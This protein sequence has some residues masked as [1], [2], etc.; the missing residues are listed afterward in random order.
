MS[1]SKVLSIRAFIPAKDLDVSRRFYQDLGF[2]QIWGDDSACG[3]EVDG[4]GI[5]LQRF[6]VKEHAENFMMALN[7]EDLDAWWRY[8]QTLGLKEKYGLGLVKE[9]QMQPW[10]IRV[11]YLCDPTG[12]LWHVAEYSKA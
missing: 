6:Y 1:R 5:I 7:V 11:L 10:G 12:V 3:M 9:P 8:I 4:C 2:R